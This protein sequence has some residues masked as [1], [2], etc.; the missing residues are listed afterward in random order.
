MNIT[1]EMLLDTLNMFLFLAVELTLLFLIIS[2]L[3]GILQEYIPPAKIEKI[4]SSKGGRGY[5]IAAVLGAT[6]TYVGAATLKQLSKRTTFIRVQEQEN[7]VY[8]KE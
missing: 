5:I 2:Y 1:N 8:G 4:L 7:N 3:V 6:C